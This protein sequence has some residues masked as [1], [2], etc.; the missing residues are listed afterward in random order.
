MANWNSPSETKGLYCSNHAKELYK[1]NE[2]V[3][4][5]NKTCLT[6]GCKKQTKL[7]KFRR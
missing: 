5:K 2:M 1:N 4:L 3:D 7:W 6:T